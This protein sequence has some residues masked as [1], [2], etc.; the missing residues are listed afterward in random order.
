MINQCFVCFVVACVQDIKP[1]NLMMCKDGV[2]KVT[3]FGLAAYSLLRDE[4]PW[5][6]KTNVKGGVLLCSSFEGGTPEYFSPEQHK[7]S[8]EWEKVRGEEARDMFEDRW[9]LTVATSDLYQAAMTILEI[10][11]WYLPT[12]VGS[13]TVTPFNAAIKCAERTPK[14]EFVTFSPEQTEDWLSDKD[15][16]AFLDKGVLVGKRFGGEKLHELSKSDWKEVKEAGVFKK[17]AQFKKS[18]SRS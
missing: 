4:D 12:S 6:R 13:S 1:A 5:T 17:I 11:A 14:S 8:S 7:I 16:G 9:R 15:I 18:Y 3:D 2:V 10:H